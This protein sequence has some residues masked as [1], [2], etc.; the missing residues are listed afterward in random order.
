LFTSEYFCLFEY[1]LQNRHA[2]PS[3]SGFTASFIIAAISAW[4][5]FSLF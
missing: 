4:E 1:L 5:Y 2:Q 3:S